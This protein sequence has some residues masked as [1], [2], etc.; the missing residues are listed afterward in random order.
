L[1]G[2]HEQKRAVIEKLAAE[3]PVQIICAV[4]D[5]PRSSYYYPAHPRDDEALK[6][7]LQEVADEWPTYGYRRLTVQVRRDK[8]MVA[9]SKRVRR[10]VKL[11]HLGRK[12]KRKARRTT[13]SEH[14]FPR[15]PN[16]V[17]DLDIV[18][19]DQV[20]VVDITY[21]RL[22]TEFVYLAVI[23]DVFTRSI[24]GW[25]LGRNLDQ[26]LTLTAL[27]CA[28]EHRKPEIHHSDQG[29]QYAATD[30]TDLLKVAGIAISMAEV[31][32]A[33]QNGYAERLIRTIKE[34]EVDLSDY[35]DYA[36]AYHQMG[37]FLEDVYMRKRIHSSLGYLTPAEF[38]DRW[39]AQQT[40]GKTVD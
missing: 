35:L 4:L 5:F 14:P 19:P 12:H 7:A 15:Y 18:R 31:G 32:E 25:Q 3:Y 8:Q 39:F 29:V 24:R 30:Y 10:L 13:N 11:M 33:T 23:M 37:R 17:Q 6:A 34:E 22:K 27:K 28:L 38:E 16:L 36:D 20:W 40:A 1:G 2:S 9:N 26:E 21:I